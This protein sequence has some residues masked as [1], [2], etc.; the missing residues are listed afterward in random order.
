MS[1]HSEDSFRP[2]SKCF[3]S[4]VTNEIL[5]GK[6]ESVQ[7]GTWEDEQVELVPIIYGDKHFDEEV[8]RIAPRGG[9]RGGRNATPKLSL[10]FN[11]DGTGTSALQEARNINSVESYRGNCDCPQALFLIKRPTS[12]SLRPI[13]ARDL[14]SM[15]Q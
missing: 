10:V 12:Y 9:S 5:F 3:P 6:F 8:E 14:I 1:S 7:L 15:R 2:A 11:G 13:S 4:A